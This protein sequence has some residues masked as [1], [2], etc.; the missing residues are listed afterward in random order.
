M[1]R[2]RM[3]ALAAGM[4]TTALL[5]SCAK[6]STPETLPDAA[7]VTQAAPRAVLTPEQLAAVQALNLDAEYIAELEAKPLYQFSESDVHVYLGFIQETIPDLRDRIVHL[8]RKNIG[9]PY[10]IY[11]LG[12]FPFETYDPQPLY[13]LDRSD[14][15]VFSEHTYAMALSHDWPSFFTMLQRIRYK[16]GQIGVA[17]RNHYTEADWD[18]NNSWLVHDITEELGGDDCVRFTTTFNTAKFLKNRYKLTTDIE[19]RKMEVAFIPW[20]KTLEVIDQLQPGTFVNVMRGRNGGYW[21]GHTGLI[22]RSEDGTVNFMH[23][24]PPRVKEQP[25]AEYIE[26]CVAANAKKAEE[27]KAVFYGFKFLQVND[28]PLA[29][30]RA[31]DGPNAPVIKPPMGSTLDGG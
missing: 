5:A 8:G 22:T 30:L 21:A 11:L 16:D 19:P 27:G 4:A 23:S 6:E 29:E 7:A 24:T 15:V 17:T 1:M 28:D 3:I 14:C 18:K 12:E 25:L 2:T 31:I 26:Q 20:Q 9:Q 13:C 10:E